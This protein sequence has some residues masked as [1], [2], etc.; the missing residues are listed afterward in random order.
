MFSIIAIYFFILGLKT[1][2]GVYWF[3]LPIILFLSFLTKQA[4]TGHIF[5]IITFLSLIFFIFNYNLRN[6][7]LGIAGSILVV[8]VFIF[9]FVSAG[10][11]FESFFLQYILY[12]LSLGEN[13]LSFIL[14]LEFSQIILRQKLIHISS[15]LLI[16]FCKGK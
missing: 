14:P 9:T 7:L 16:I 1:N 11:P 12:P 15:V 3:L 10:I 6:I 4:P 2:K 8:L 13:R 5:I